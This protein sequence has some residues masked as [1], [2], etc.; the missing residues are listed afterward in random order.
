MGG[1]S[2]EEGCAFLE[3]D[4][5]DLGIWGIRDMWIGTHRGYRGYRAIREQE[6][7]DI[8]IE[9]YRD[10]SRTFPDKRA[11]Q[12]LLDGES[13]LHAPPAKRAMREHG[14]TTLDDWP[15]YSPEL[16]PQEHVPWKP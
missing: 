5:G 4:S 12:L 16:N 10:K 13:L 8:R 11:F 7:R 9:G 6:Y 2:E 15:G 1:F 3:E 14:I